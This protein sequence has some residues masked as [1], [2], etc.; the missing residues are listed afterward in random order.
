M[1]VELFPHN[2]EAY[3]AVCIMLE[4][5]NKACVIHPTGTGKSFIGFRYAEDH[6][7]SQILWLAPSTYIYETQMENWLKAGGDE[8][9]NISFM[10]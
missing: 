6:K 5:Q 9:E 4:E 7:S 1:S 3:D 2:Q 8:L 10:T